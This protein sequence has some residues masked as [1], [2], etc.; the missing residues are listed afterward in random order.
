MPVSV[1][2]DQT[3]PAR[4]ARA[5]GVVY[6]PAAV[7]H[8]MVRLAIDPLARDRSADEILALRVCDPAVGEG[9]FL[10]EV[11]NVLAEHM[12]RARRKSRVR[13]GDLDEARQEIARTCIFGIDVDERAVAKARAAT[14]ASSSQLPVG[15][16]LEIDWGRAFPEV[17]ARGGFDV[18]IANPP[19]VRQE[20]LA[21]HKP[22][23]KR[24]KTYD[25][26]A[27]LYVY[28]I[29]LA[30]QLARPGGRYCL[31]TPNKWLTA[32]YGRPLRSYLA[33]QG[34]VDGIVDLAQAELFR[35]ADA[36]PSIMWGTTGGP[37]TTPIRAAKPASDVAVEI[38]LSD[39][40]IDHE[41]ARW[42]RE[43]WHIDAPGDRRL[44]ARLE[45]TWTRLGDLLNQ[46]PSR[47]VVTG[48]N[49]AFVIERDTRDRLLEASPSSAALIRP[50]IKG[51]D[52]RPW[53][54]GRSERWIL[55]VD[56]GT[57]IDRYP[58]IRDY[59]AELRPALE[60]RASSDTP[61]PGRKPGRYA[62][63][64]L[65][66]PVGPLVKHPAPR[67]LYQDI[68]T[69]PACCFDAE[70]IVVPDTTVWILPSSDPFLLA[71]LNSSLYG[72]YARR[73][74]PP[75]LNGA[76][77]PKADYVLE[78]PIATPDDSEQIAA[79]VE[80]RIAVE[81]DTS[82]HTNRRRRELDAALDDAVVDAY[83]LTPAERRIVAA[84]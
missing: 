35:D 22:A 74:F 16:A 30:H 10:I 1:S 40:G 54:A 72:W 84:G 18:V 71:V 17:F 61:G 79:L 77:R 14:C 73:R 13:R 47:G 37:R 76:V 45:R 46:R 65:Q 41:R 66:D 39:A 15:N 36:F 78:L 63:F 31:I 20:Q 25:G 28:F 52:V 69:A 62:W 23:L 19:Y 34:T 9:A 8:P 64:E 11:V 55:L 5:A 24:F 12:V 21:H 32:A 44:I 7:A 80:Q 51:R 2:S 43:P 50:F 68:Q 3:G 38:A 48:C 42:G 57:P 59:L 70:G 60:P 6:T 83:Q 33:E 26:V 58:A 4:A 56:H 27:D 75:A 53:M 82:A 67:L 81:R 49:R 29:E